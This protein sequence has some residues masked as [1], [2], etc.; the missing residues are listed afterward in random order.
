MGEAEV[1]ALLVD[2]LNHNFR[3]SAAETQRALNN[4]SV[5]IS[6]TLDAPRAR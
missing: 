5:K 4:S 3:R 1:G 6:E 2:T